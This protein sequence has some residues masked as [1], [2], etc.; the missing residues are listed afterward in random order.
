MATTPDGETD[1]FDNLAFKDT[2]AGMMN[3][4]TEKEQKVLNLRYGLED[5]IPRTLDEVGGI[6]GVTRERVRQ[7]ESK[8]FDKIRERGEFARDILF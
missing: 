7:I 4:L 2:L 3:C 5:Q 8:A 1:P 6:I